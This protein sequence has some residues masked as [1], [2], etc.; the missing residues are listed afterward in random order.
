VN[1]FRGVMVLF[2]LAL[3]LPG[4]DRSPASPAASYFVASVDGSVRSEYSGGGTLH[5]GTRPTGGR[6]FSIYSEGEAGHSG[7]HFTIRSYDSAVPRAGTY[8]LRLLDGD[9]SNPANTGFGAQ[10]WRTG[11]ENEFFVADSG[12]VTVERVRSGRMEGRFEFSGFRFCTEVSDP[13]PGGG[14]CVIPAAAPG[15]APRITVTGRFRVSPP[16][17]RYSPDVP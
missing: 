7:Q 14:D 12:T 6:T 5:T 10:H 11:E 17:G 15:E 16:E 13:A 8:P 9:V 3:V 2:G 1:A 4:C